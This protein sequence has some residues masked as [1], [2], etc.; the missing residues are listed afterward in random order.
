[1]LIP[2][3]LQITMDDVGWFC[4]VD[5]REHGGSARAAMPRRRCAKD[6]VAVFFVKMNM[7]YK[8]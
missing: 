3:A 5:D 4:G 8:K 2:Y 7:K 1:M 6:Y